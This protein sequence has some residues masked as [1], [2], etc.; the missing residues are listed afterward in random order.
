MSFEWPLMLWLL[1]AAPALA[2]AYLLALRRKKAASLRFSATGLVREA[3]G[4]GLGWRRH[5]P[6]AL[7]LLALVA[8]TFALA[9]PS[10]VVTL[11]SGNQTVILAMDISGSM[12]AKDIPPSRFEAM[13]AAARAFVKAQ[14]ANVDI[15]VVAFAATATLVQTPTKDREEV[16]AAIDRFHQQ[17]G[18]AVGS[19][20]LTSLSAIF[21]DAKIDI[22]PIETNRAAP[23]DP[24]APPPPPPP[25]PVEPGSFRSAVIIL[26]TDGQANT[27]PNPIDAARR[28]ADLGVRV[29]TV[30]LGTAKG[31]VI[32]YEGWS[33]RAQ[34]DE[35][36]L[37]T[38]ADLT[39]GKYFKADS[40]TNLLGIYHDLGL[41]LTMEKQRTEITALFTAFAAALVLASSILSMLWFGRI[42]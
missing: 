15:G 39:R 25:A 14:P 24:N 3:M 34:L 16:L 33:M 18:T 12:R 22:G 19:G 41:Q 23:L 21:E 29:F 20:I 37:K 26:L 42:L 36:S 4:R 9:R 30:G 13:Q 17:R 38:I 28:A 11:L 8:M 31:A 35:A 1:L 27:G 32:G 10:A 5:L 40:D 7:T 2:A 6:P